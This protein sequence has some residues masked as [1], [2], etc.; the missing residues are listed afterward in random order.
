MI[1]WS[2]PGEDVIITDFQ[3]QLIRLTARQWNHILEGHPYM[4]NMEG[5]VQETLEDPEEIRRSRSD[6]ATVK[7]YYRWFTNTTKG[8]K[9][10]LVVVKFLENDAF[11]LTAYLT[12]KIMPGELIWQKQF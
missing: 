5:A 10:V 1:G 6:P 2:S 3:G 11:V 8:N 7:L 4:V 9:W 12:R